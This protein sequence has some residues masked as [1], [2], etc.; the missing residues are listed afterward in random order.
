L[1][2]LQKK[3]TAIKKIIIPNYRKLN[4]MTREKN[5]RL[6]QTMKKEKNKKP[7]PMRR[8]ERKKVK[9]IFKFLFL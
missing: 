8:K 7:N 9:N 6:N 2:G 5:R 1:K 3:N 4:P